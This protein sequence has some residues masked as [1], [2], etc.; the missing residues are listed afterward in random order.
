M[1]GPGI[2]LFVVMAVLFGVGGFVVRLSLARQIARDAGQ[3][4][5]KAVLTTALSDNGLAA[6]YVAG[7]LAPHSSAPSTED[8]LAELQRLHEQGLVTEAEYATKRAEIL[9]EL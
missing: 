4:E 8:R 7:A 5:T 2:G 1:Q 3:D 6:T 9:D